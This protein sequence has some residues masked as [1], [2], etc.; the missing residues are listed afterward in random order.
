MDCIFLVRVLIII[1]RS[2]EERIKC[3]LSPGQAIKY[4]DLARFCIRSCMILR[5]HTENRDSWNL[6][7]FRIRESL[8]ILFSYRISHKR[9]QR[10]IRS[11][12]CLILWITIRFQEL[13]LFVRSRLIIQEL[14][15]DF[16]TMKASVRLFWW[17]CS[18]VLENCAFSDIKS[19]VEKTLI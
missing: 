13:R 5:N 1:W 2:T 11:S 12:K 17:N 6:K 3:W 7:V 19:R 14:V 15:L 16:L 10:I 9:L 8:K 4:Q 18:N